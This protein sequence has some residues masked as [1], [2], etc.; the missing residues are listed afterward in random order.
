MKKSLS[1]ILQPRAQS[2]DLTHALLSGND[3]LIK[4]ICHVKTGKTMDHIISDIGVQYTVGVTGTCIAGS[5]IF[6]MP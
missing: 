2:V 4:C 5:G 6:I 1:T 3:L